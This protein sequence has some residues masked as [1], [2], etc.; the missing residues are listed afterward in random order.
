MKNEMTKV[1]R[2]IDDW[3]PVPLIPEGQ[4]NDRLLAARIS[5]IRDMNDRIA[6]IAKGLRVYNWA[7]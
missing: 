3:T 2:N 1:A 7:A 5:F 4:C 6:P